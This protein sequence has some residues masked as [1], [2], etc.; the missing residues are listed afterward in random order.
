MET[1]VDARGRVLIPQP[2]R[3]DFGLGEGVVVDVRKG[4]GT[5]VISRAERK[6]RTWKELNGIKHK[7]TGKPEW[8]TPEE[9]KSIWE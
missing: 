6:R 9:I 2:L 1:V 7:R 3:E 4:K 8:P 5:I